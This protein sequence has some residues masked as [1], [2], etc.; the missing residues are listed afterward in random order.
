MFDDSDEEGEAF[1][2]F[3]NSV[4]KQIGTN[5]EKADRIHENENSESEAGSNSGSDMEYSE[6]EEIAVKKPKLS[7]TSSEGKSGSFNFTGADVTDPESDACAESDDDVQNGRSDISKSVMEDSD[8]D[9]DEEDDSNSD[10]DSE[11]SEEEEEDIVEEADSESDEEDGEEEGHLKWKAKMAASAAESFKRRKSDRINY[12]KLIYGK[13][14]FT[15][16]YS[17][18]LLFIYLGDIQ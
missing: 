8:D 2:L 18:N 16:E 5:S 3:S 7:R 11:G 1:S 17:N 6:E 10:E 14:L 15:R 12:R 4:K 9:V 13:G